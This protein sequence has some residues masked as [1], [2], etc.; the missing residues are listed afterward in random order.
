[1]INSQFSIKT[2]V[3]L[4]VLA[5]AVAFPLAVRA[6]EQPLDTLIPKLSSQNADT[7]YAAHQE[8][9]KLALK[10]GRPG[11]EA[12]RAALT[13]AIAEKAVDP[14]VPQ[15]TRVWLVR[16]LE[17]IGTGDSVKPLTKILKGPDA[18]LRECARRALEQNSAP[19]AAKSLRAALEK[20]GST[21]WKIGLIRSLGQRRDAASVRLIARFLA[22]PEFSSVAAAAL[23]NIATPAAVDALWDGLKR[24]APGS[25]EALV[26]VASRLA[27]DEPAK[28]A[29]IY[30]RL[31]LFDPAASWRPAVLLGLAETAPGDAKALLP[32]A[33]AGDSPKLQAAALSAAQNLYGHDLSAFL[34]GVLPT[35]SDSGKIMAFE[36]LDSSAESAVSS[37]V[38][39]PN[40]E[41]RV[42][43]VET[44]GR[45]G[46][47]ASLPLLLKTAAQDSG[48]E[49]KAAASA[50]AKISDPRITAALLETV[51]GSGEL[52]LRRAAINALV[53]RNEHGAS[54]AVFECATNLQAEPE[55]R[56]AA[57]NALGRLGTDAELEP[58]VRLALD[59]SCPDAESAAR[60]IAGRVG[61]K[62]AAANELLEMAKQS[63][64]TNCAVLYGILGALGGN[65]ALSALTVAATNSASDL[66]AAAVHALADWPDFSAANPLL[67]V[68]TNSQTTLA[69]NA[70][71]IQGVVRLLNNEDNDQKPGPRVKVALAALQ[72]ARRDDERKLVLS[73]F[74]SFAD[75][76][77]ADAI[78]PLLSE[79]GLKLEAGLAGT[80]LA[81]ELLKSYKSAA[82]GL[83][84][85]I[86]EAKLSDE[87]TLKADKIL[88]DDHAQ[89][90]PP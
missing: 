41:V 88:K 49:Q 22:Q 90:D 75:P 59:G 7:N 24:G 40:K 77:L 21:A 66:E 33:L 47:S 23:G 15:P 18:E 64:P 54:A 32:Q 14:S 67:E 78:K 86:K 52:K 20:G 45:I 5:F 11:A 42:A 16:Q 39:A 19:E 48:P 58:M 56:T 73:T 65:E 63:D 83:A 1:M 81:K 71:A 80:N 28:S 89:A 60:S 55:L 8:L 74:S 6:T 79:P 9:Q 36:Y 35:L 87:L 31:G 13:K 25:G 84:Q 27:K 62:A 51:A 2:R 82:Q 61:D 46:T 57:V 17:Y 29:A 76:K 85:A 43:A 10:S 12:E 34:A 50:L 72:A 4:F 53:Q 69:N 70:I 26:M 37:A 38:T 30:K 3:V 44:L 68:A